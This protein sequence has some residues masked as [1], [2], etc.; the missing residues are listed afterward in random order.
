MDSSTRQGLT[1]TS[2]DHRK[3]AALALEPVLRELATNRT[4][5]NEQKLRLY[6]VQ[7]VE[8]AGTRLQSSTA[9]TTNRSGGIMGLAS[10]AIALGPRL[11][12][13]LGAIIRPVLACFEDHDSKL[14]YYACESLYNIAKVAHGEILVYFNELFDALAKLV[15]DV[16]PSVKNGAEL[17]DRLLKDIVTEQASTYVSL[18]NYSEEE[19]EDYSLMSAREI[20]EKVR[21]R[22]GSPSRSAPSAPSAIKPPSRAFSLSRFIP[23]LQERF[24]VLDP[25][26]RTFLISWLIVLDSVPELELIS[27]LPEFLGGLLAYLGDPTPEVRNGAEGLLRD[28]LCETREV[29]EIEV[30]RLLA[31]REKWAKEVDRKRRRP[32]EAKTVTVTDTDNG[33][34]DAGAEQGG[35]G[36]PTPRSGGQKVE[37]G[38]ADDYALA[39]SDEE[40]E[41]EVDGSQEWIPGQGVK[42]D[43]P[44]VVEIL[45]ETVSFPDEQIQRTCLDWLSQFLQFVPGV[46]VPF[47]PRLI[48]VILSA[49]AHHVPEIEHVAQNTNDLLYTVVWSLPV[50]SPLPPGASL[51]PSATQPNLAQPSTHVPDRASAASPPPSSFPFPTASAATPRPGHDRHKPG[52]DA[53][54]HL[55]HHAS[56]TAL[57]SITSAT[58]TLTVSPPSEDSNL[59]PPPDLIDPYEPDGRQFQYGLTVNELTLQF[60]S[61]S[62]ETRVAA[63]EWLLMLHQKA[64]R[65]TLVGDDP[66]IQARRDRPSAQQ[67]GGRQRDLSASSTSSG[68]S[69]AVLLK[70][71]SDPS[72]RVLRSDLV[73]LAQISS[74]GDGDGGD[75]YFAGLMT[76][77]LE[78]FSTDRKLLETRGS[79]II[80]QLCGSL[81]AERIYR[82]CAEILEK[83]EDLEFA[84]I[85]VQNLNLIMITS[86][87]LSEFRKRLRT[88][89]SKD[90]QNLFVTLYRSWSHNAVATFTLCLLAQAYEQAS[91]LLQIFAELEMTVP[92]LIQIDKLVQLIESPVF[93]S[94]RLQLLEPE[95]Y[96]YLLKAMYG[97]LMLL[98]Q[99]SAFATLRNR[100]SAVS[101]LGFLQTVPRASVISPS[102]IRTSGGLPSSASAGTGPVSSLARGARTDIATP[103]PP[104]IRW[105]ELLAHFRQVQKRR[106]AALSSTS[107]GSTAAG[108]APAGRGPTL[109]SPHSASAG[110]GTV[111]G[112]FDGYEASDTTSMRGVSGGYGGSSTVGGSRFVGTATKRG[113]APTSSHHPFQASSRS[114]DTASMASSTLSGGRRGGPIVAAASAVQRALSPTMQGT[115]SRIGSASNGRGAAA[116]P[117]RS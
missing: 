20:R 63:L 49:L 43:Y 91:A 65:K 115:K 110:Y 35:K 32:S 98:P 34:D 111:R 51:S 44:A 77:L 36:T 24:A 59:A 62:E 33:G 11:A 75:D 10:L 102:A 82:I 66:S 12:D 4:Q 64:P 7:L 58:S 15:S 85:M 93:T 100:L 112:G 109:A 80:R 117:R 57:T 96:P 86:P 46:V 103:D 17:L 31:K 90:G 61:D 37:S 48:P 45:A 52:S 27:Y 5:E 81:N 53:A 39:D 38:R 23:L 19:D 16:D 54:S 41:E 14:R 73:L 84:S 94:L 92:M 21:Q 56:A 116:G 105:N 106:A 104:S 87:E 25:F 22:D 83:D 2:Y 26:T 30:D 71:L 8:L 74:I 67:G 50:D 88:L 3:R 13:F 69:L 89:D 55:H 72:D 101:S 95:R 18:A 28:M 79:L 6:I 70:L 76:S 113:T 114:G 29:R 99:S 42:I 97:L 68:L 107:G 78:L 1:N 47:V 108:P 60:L 9:T 40:Y